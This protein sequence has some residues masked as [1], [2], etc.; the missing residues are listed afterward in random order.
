MPDT[1]NQQEAVIDKNIAHKG[2][3]FSCQINTDSPVMVSGSIEEKIW[4]VAELCKTYKK[5]WWVR[6]GTIMA[7]IEIR[8]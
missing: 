5:F 2:K 4:T 7:S 1:R 3:E 8:V 6:D